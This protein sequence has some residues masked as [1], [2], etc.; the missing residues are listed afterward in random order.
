MSPHR[1]ASHLLTALR[2]AVDDESVSGIFLDIWGF[3]NMAV[4]QEI[5]NEMLL[6]R[7]RGKKV[8]AYMAGGG[9]LTDYLV[10]SA[11]DTIVMPETMMIGPFGLMTRIQLMKGL[12]DKLGFE[13]ERYPCRKCDYKA[14]Y[15]QLTDEEIPEEFRKELNSILDDWLDQYI[16]DIVE[17]RGLNREDF[18]EVC[19]GRLILAS[20]A[21]ELGLVDVLAYSDIADS[22]TNQMTKS[23]II[24]GFEIAKE[25]QRIYAW[26]SPPAVAVVAAMGSISEGR[27]RSGFLDG[28]V[29]GSETLIQTIRQVQ[30]DPDVK[31]VVLRIDSPGG[32]GYAS[33]MIWYQIED[34]KKRTQ[35]P[36]V[37]SM[38][39]VA[40]SGGYYI[41][42]NSDKI[43]ANPATITGSIGVTGMKAITSRMYSK[44]GIRSEIFKRGEHVDMLGTNRR[45]TD[46]EREM[47]LDVVD[48]FYDIF[49]SK[50]A[51]GRGMTQERVFDLAA[52]R[53]YTGRQA[54]D[55]DL[56]DRLGGVREAVDLAWEMAGLEGRPRVVYYHRPRKSLWQRI[57]GIGSAEIPDFHTIFETPGPMAYTELGAALAEMH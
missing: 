55:N 15:F 53:I 33:D 25:R 4:A 7:E 44:I 57:T 51:E 52:G 49:T 36:F 6:A 20:D 9:G 26:R 16:S 8:I 14:A 32:S 1:G 19:D 35:K 37:S 13:F 18:E 3:S 54:L 2:R 30:N 47:I 43:V 31:A 41:A 45:T 46:E 12:M 10:A 38:G 28:N 40:G 17:A 56:V 23:R 11:A 34:L 50:V 39:I 42:M 24:G 48:D 21:K 29:I 27:N 22:L 5:R